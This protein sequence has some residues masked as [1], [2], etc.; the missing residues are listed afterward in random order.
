MISYLVCK[1]GLKSIGYVG[2]IYNWF[3]K[4]NCV[5]GLDIFLKEMDIGL[6]LIEF[7]GLVINL[8]IGEYLCGVVGFWVEKGKI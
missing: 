5:G 4:L 6:F 7:L 3:V 2:G 1:M 8:V